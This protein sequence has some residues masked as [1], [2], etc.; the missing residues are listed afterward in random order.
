MEMWM[1]IAWAAVLG[2]LI[3]RMW[4]VARH[5]MENGPK[6]TPD[7]WRAALLPIAG[8]VGFVLLLIMLVRG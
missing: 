3:V 4:P 8:V 2:M 7:D 1:K 5:W 6:G